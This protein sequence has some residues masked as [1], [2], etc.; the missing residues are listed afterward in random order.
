LICIFLP[1]P[2][3]IPDVSGW[4]S[5]PYTVQLMIYLGRIIEEHLFAVNQKNVP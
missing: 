1:Y 2:E 5:V 4:E 3:F